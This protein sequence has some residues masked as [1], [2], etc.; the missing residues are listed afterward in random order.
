MGLK[1]DHKTWKLIKS[2]KYNIIR[3][4]HDFEHLIKDFKVSLPSL[5]NVVCFLKQE[6]CPFR[7]LFKTFSL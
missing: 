5:R 1:I 6:I 2:E 3:I 4:D 7:A